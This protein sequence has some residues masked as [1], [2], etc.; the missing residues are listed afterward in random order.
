MRETLKHLRQICRQSRAFRV[1]LMVAL[2][3]TALRWVVQI[4]LLVSL[5]LFDTGGITV[6]VDLKIYMDAAQ[7]F[8]QKQDLYPQGPAPIEVYQYTPA[9][10]LLFTSFLLLPKAAVVA[11]HTFLHLFAYGLL[12]IQWSRIFSELG[13]CQANEMLALTL[14]IWLVFSSFWT[15]LGYLN[16]YIIVTLLAT[17]LIEAVLSERLRWSLLWLSVILQIK[18]HWAFVV[19]VPLLLGQFRYFF[20]LTGLAM[21][22]YAIVVSI[23]ILAAGP[24]YGWLQ[25]VDYSRFLLNMRDYFPWRGSEA[26]FLGYNHSI[27]Q[28]VVYLF[29]I[30][31][32]SFCLATLFKILF[33]SPLTIVSFRNLLRPSGN[34]GHEIPRL[35]LDLTFTLYLGIFIWLDMVWEVSL[36]IVIFPYLLA[37]LESRIV[38]VIAGAVFLPYAL[39]D[40]WRLGSFALSMI[41][42]NTIASGLYILTDPNIYVPLMMI[43]IL[44]FYVILIG[45]LWNAAPALRKQQ[46][47]G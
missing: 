18:P 8:L 5:L 31:P 34:P 1:V 11:I 29:G 26:S 7:R 35:A 38:K 12:Y 32:R 27:T 22:T 41:G 9:Y 15:D 30:S 10:A 3:Y 19:A 25:Y 44:T 39:L 23:V 2:A 42:V 24:R 43:V 28:V 14:P 4:A 33:L 45:R 37:T 46:A 20:K 40:P 36:S 6:P 21:L 13:L 17:L 16:I 47:R